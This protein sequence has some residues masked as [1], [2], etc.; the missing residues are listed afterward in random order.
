MPNPELTTIEMQKSCLGILKAFDAFCRENNLTYYLAGGTMLGAIRHKGFIPWDDDVDLMMPRADYEKMMTIPFNHERY[1]F[2]SLKTDPEYTRPW[3]RIVDT[4]TEQFS[5]IYFKG[6]T[7]AVFIDIAPIDGLPASHAAT[8]FHYA[9]LRLLDALNKGAKRNFIEENERW[10][11]LKR[12]AQRLFGQ[13]GARKFAIM[14]DKNAQRKSFEKSAW[15]GV[16]VVYHYGVREKLPAHAFDGTVYKD[17]EDMQ[18]PLFVGYEIYLKNIYG[19][20]M[21][22]PPEEKRVLAH[23]TR[24]RMAEGK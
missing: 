5:Q 3:V 8:K 2:Y 16:S 1:R 23:R 4:H 9:R 14:I 17:F 24:Y 20:Y 13:K 15:R 19:D 6:D 12:F 11:F 18:A 10:A 7:A 21:Q 22:L